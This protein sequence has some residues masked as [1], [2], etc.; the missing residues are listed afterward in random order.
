MKIHLMFINLE[1][2][3]V[4][5]PIS[6]LLVVL[7]A[8]EINKTQIL[9]RKLSEALWKYETIRLYHFS[10]QKDLGKI[11]VFLLPFLKYALGSFKIMVRKML[12]NGNKYEECM[13]NYMQMTGYFYDVED[14]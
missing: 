6:K 5:V 8:F 11:V 7:H 9:F 4:S 3:C 13:Y 14:I 10:Y 12:L 2:A 1:K